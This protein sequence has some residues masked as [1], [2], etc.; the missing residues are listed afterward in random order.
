[1]TIQ[2]CY[3]IMGADYDD[4]LRRFK[5]EE[6]IRMFIKMLLKDQNYNHLCDS[7][8]HQDYETAFIA[9]HTLKGIALNLGLTDLIHSSSELTEILRFKKDD[10][11]IEQ[12]MQKV[13]SDY[14]QMISL[15]SEVIDCEGKK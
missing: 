11:R 3:E 5:K 6:R 15:L 2:E 14:T 8:V 13:K 12:L 4:L 1:M 7:L 10:Y 9:I